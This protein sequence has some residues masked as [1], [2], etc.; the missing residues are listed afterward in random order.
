[1]NYTTPIR[2]I[3]MG[4]PDFALPSL[5]RLH[6]SG[7]I[8]VIAV[9]TQPDRP[10]G[11]GNKVAVSPVKQFALEHKLAVIQPASL[12]KEPQVIEQL[13]ALAPDLIVV[14]AYGLILPKRLL[15]IAKYG[16]INVHGSILP[17]YRGA[18]PIAAAILDGQTETGISIMLMD[19]GLDTGPVLAIERTS[20]QATDTTASL[21]VKLAELGADLLLRT[22]LG[23][24]G[25]RLHPT[26]QSDLPG[27]SSICQQIE[28]DAGKID[29]TQ[30]ADQIER[31]T[32]AYTPW[33]SAFTLWKGELFKIWQTEVL[34]GNAAP[35]EVVTVGKAVA[36]GTGRGLLELITV[37]P[38]GKKALDIRSFLN[39]AGGFVG[40]KLG[41]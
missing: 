11:R 34:E 2:A 24:I 21:T 10:A 27:E 41:Q 30:P 1:M 4:T 28:K 37:Q 23:W 12:R 8:D 40:S 33:P 29:W 5:Q 17:A 36:V 32:R 7:W 6:T 14:A 31:M 39:G 22:L 9:L 38:A 16:C 35:G 3:F 18:S 15:A 20:I 13:E 26:D 25:G 19:V